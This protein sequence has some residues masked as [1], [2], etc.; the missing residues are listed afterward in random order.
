[1]TRNGQKIA[2]YE[3]QIL[4]ITLYKRE[5]NRNKNIQFWILAPQIID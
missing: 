2:I 3:S 5:Y 1:M 4:G